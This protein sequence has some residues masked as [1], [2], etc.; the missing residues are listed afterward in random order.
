VLQ[1]TEKDVKAVKY[2]KKEPMEPHLRKTVLNAR[3]GIILLLVGF[4]AVCVRLENF[5]TKRGIN[6]VKIV[7]WDIATLLMVHRIVWNAHWGKALQMSPRN[8][9]RFFS[10]WISLHPPF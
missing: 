2:V 3:P 1:K 10:I 4:D 8:T 9:A 7:L 5:L 6:S